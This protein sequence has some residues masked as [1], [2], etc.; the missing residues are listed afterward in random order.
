M[1]TTRLGCEDG[2]AVRRFMQGS[3]YSIGEHLAFSLIAAG[4]ALPIPESHPSSKEFIMSSICSRL[5]VRTVAPASEPLT[6]SETKN[7]LR[8]DHTADDAIITDLITSARMAAEE[9]LKRSLITQTWKLAYDDYVSES[10]PLAMGPV[11]AISSV[12]IVARDGTTQ[13]ASSDTYYLNAAK[14]TVLF[15]SMIIGFR[16]EITYNTGYGS[17]SAV[18]RP[19]KYGMLSHIAAMYDNRGD[20]KIPE[21]S[22][23]LYLPFR[24]VRL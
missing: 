3:I 2:F 5:L 13:T 18:P 23:A 21:Q 7:Y 8:V 12:I 16:I 24:E 11:T 6:L 22:T 20:H 10:I 1:L 4:Q 14:D 9:W 19:I 17:A 15:D